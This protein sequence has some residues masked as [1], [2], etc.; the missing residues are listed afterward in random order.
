MSKS[1]NFGQLLG[2]MSAARSNDFDMSISM[3]NAS[4]MSSNNLGG[5][6]SMG[7]TPFKLGMR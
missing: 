5:G 3:K 4:T 1:N 6:A 2:S 7:L